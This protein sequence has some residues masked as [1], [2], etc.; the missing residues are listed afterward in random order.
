MCIRDRKN[1]RGGIAEMIHFVSQL[2]HYILFEVIEAGWEGLQKALRTPDATLDDLI[3]A[4]GAYLR[5]ITRK[6]LLA[7]SGSQAS[8]STAPDFTAQLHE[9]LKLMLSYKDAVDSLYSFSVAEFTRRQDLAAKIETRTAA[10]TWGVTEKDD[11]RAS[12]RRQNDREDNDSPIPPLLPFSSNTTAADETAILTSL[13]QR[14]QTLATDFRARV[15]ILLGDLAY[16]PDVDMRFLGVVMN[17]NDVYAPV[18]RGHGHHVHGGAAKRRQQQQ[19]EREKEG[20]EREKGKGKE[21]ERVKRTRDEGEANG[22]A[23]ASK[24]G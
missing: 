17:F 5:S 19:Q 9:L 3:S 7:P 14:L 22:G 13:R 23:A 4:H 21:R 18:R 10:G 12:S 2:Q 16:Q 6:G 24:E 1:A 11:H 15:N 20:G 8:S